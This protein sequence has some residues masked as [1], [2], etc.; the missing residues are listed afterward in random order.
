MPC[1]WDEVGSVWKMLVD[2]AEGSGHAKTLT[3]EVLKVL[4]TIFFKMLSASLRKA[5]YGL[6]DKREERET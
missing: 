6:N 3:K 1:K 2:K 5:R 4:N